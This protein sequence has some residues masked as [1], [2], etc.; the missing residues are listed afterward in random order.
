M[1]S[2]IESNCTIS[3]RVGIDW[4]N[5]SRSPELSRMCARDTRNEWML[6]VKALGH[7]HDLGR[8]ISGQTNQVNK[9]KVKLFFE[10][11]GHR[12]SNEGAASYKERYNVNDNQRH[13]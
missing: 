8:C 4:H 13:C 3:K 5:I 7:F 11:H 12:S 2:H 6:F 10:L 1:F 9:G